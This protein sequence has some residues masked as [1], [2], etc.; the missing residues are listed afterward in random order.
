MTM[1]S[2]IRAAFLFICTSLCELTIFKIQ[3]LNE[4]ISYKH[5]YNE[6]FVLTGFEV[7]IYTTVFLVNENIQQQFVFVLF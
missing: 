4:Q 2:E 1:F 3:S 7:C 6:V 5:V